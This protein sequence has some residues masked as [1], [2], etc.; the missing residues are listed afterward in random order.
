MKVE[1]SY[2][3][4][5]TVGDRKLP[6]RLERYA[7]LFVD[8]TYGVVLDHLIKVELAERLQLGFD[9]FKILSIR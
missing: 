7:T 6:E 8:T 3:L 9:D 5:E 2:L 1:V 4:F